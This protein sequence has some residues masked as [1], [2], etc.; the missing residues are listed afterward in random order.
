MLKRVIARKTEPF[1]HLEVTI[2]GNYEEVE[3][4][5]KE[6]PKLIKKLLHQGHLENGYVIDYVSIT[7]KECQ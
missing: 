7:K 5:Q 3:A 1:K 2:K 6:M 4:I